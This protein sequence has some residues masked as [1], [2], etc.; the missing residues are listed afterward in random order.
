M[1]N[2]KGKKLVVLGAMAALLTLIGVSGSQ[3]YAKYV[4]STE[5]DAKSAT[6]AKW[7]FVYNADISKLFGDAYDLDGDDGSTVG[8]YTADSSLV[9]KASASAK[10]VVAPGTKGQMTFSIIGEAEVDVDLDITMPTSVTDIFLDTDGVAGGRYYPLKWTLSLDDT[11]DGNSNY[12]ALVENKNLADCLNELSD[13]YHYPAGTPVYLN[14]KLE[15]RWDLTNSGKTEVAVAASIGE[16]EYADFLTYDEADTILAIL[17]SERTG[18]GLQFNY[19]NV[20]T[21][22]ASSEKTVSF[23][24]FTISLT[25]V[26][27]A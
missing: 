15:W 3:T 23:T 12:T 21:S 13:K 19:D 24:D 7:G 10:N 9:V 20:K 1:K 22:Y 5:V 18:N 17:N 4:E 25:Q 8:V 6:V 14:Y 27:N 11:N 26:Q 16:T 2:K